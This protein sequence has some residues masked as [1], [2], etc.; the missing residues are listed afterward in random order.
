M[1]T[2]CF[3]FQPKHA[4]QSTR[5]KQFKMIGHDIRFFTSY[6]HFDTL[7]VGL[8]V[9]GTLV[10]GCLNASNADAKKGIFLGDSFHKVGTL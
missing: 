6:P 3:R 4:K 7:L 2:Y 10:R 9:N 8:C 5:C 1:K